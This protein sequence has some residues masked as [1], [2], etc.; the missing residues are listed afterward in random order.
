MAGEDGDLSVGL[1]VRRFAADWICNGPPG[2]A[3]ASA[4]TGLF[5]LISMDAAFLES[6]DLSRRFLADHGTLFVTFIGAQFTLWLGFK[7]VNRLIDRK[8]EE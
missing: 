3:W 6:G 1:A 2:W 7:G 8:A 5:L 4:Q